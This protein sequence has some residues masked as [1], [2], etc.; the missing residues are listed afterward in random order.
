MCSAG[1]I[2]VQRPAQVSWRWNKISTPSPHLKSLQR[3][4]EPP[5]I[6]V[7][8]PHSSFLAITTP[9]PFLQ[10]LSSF[11]PFSCHHFFLFLHETFSKSS[12]LC[13]IPKCSLCL[14]SKINHYIILFLL[15]NDSVK[16]NAWLNR[17]K[18]LRWM[19]DSKLCWNW[20]KPGSIHP[21]CGCFLLQP[22]C[23]T[24]TLFKQSKL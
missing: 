4:D 17:L 10:Y 22:H 14:L 15:M 23:L 8:I 18:R 16:E 19:V 11:F 7:T 6:P 3:G 2:G 12:F 20:T 13:H 5:S 21:N 24:I 9:S 1:V